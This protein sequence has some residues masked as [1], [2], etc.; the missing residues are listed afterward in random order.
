MKLLVFA[1]QV[2]AVLC[3]VAGAATVVTELSPRQARIGEELVLSVTVSGA[4]GRP[5]SV[6]LPED[7]PFELLHIDTAAYAKTGALAYVLAVYD[8]GRFELPPL[9]VVV[10]K[11]GGADTLY[12]QP[13]HV[14]IVSSLPDT[15]AAIRGLK[16]Y[17]EQKFRWR[18]LY[19]YWWIPTAIALAL[20]AWWIWRRYFRK[21]TAAE[22]A[23]LEPEL[24]PYEQ[25]VRDLLLLK[26]R[27]YPE[28]GMMKEFYVD[29]SHIMR[30]YLERRFGF[31]ALEMTTFELEYELDDARFHPQLRQ[32]LLPVLQESDLVKFAKLIPSPNRAGQ[33]IEL[34]YEMLVLTKVESEAV[35]P[36]E[37]AAA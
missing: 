5:V 37:A 9:P 16:P 27:K 34:G 30:N 32:R 29:Y 31:P 19:A 7:T 35:R 36:E 25:A 28:R 13:Q 1:V 4:D 21:Q 6:Q 17:R 24:P 3:S 18:E 8:T 15:A 14:V 26:D 2:I 10:G 22:I 12:T 20:G 23:A 33:C 11:A